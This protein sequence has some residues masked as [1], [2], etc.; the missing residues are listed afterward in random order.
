[1][2][3]NTLCGKKNK[4]LYLYGYSASP[5][6]SHSARIK[7]PACHRSNALLSGSKRTEGITQF[8]GQCKL[9]LLEEKFVVE[10]LEIGK[11][12]FLVENYQ[13]N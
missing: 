7:K 9:Q 12:K 4:E 5:D 1:M 13:K 8:E 11:E 10:K 3:P 6:P 2:N